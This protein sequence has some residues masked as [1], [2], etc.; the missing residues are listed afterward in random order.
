MSKKAD[1]E[2]QK[3]DEKTL[4]SELLE[5]GKLTLIADSRPDIDK[6]GEDLVASLPTGTKWTCNVARLDPETNKFNQTYFII[7]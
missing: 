1:N 7:K 3:A 4:A 5:N 6:Q 2:G